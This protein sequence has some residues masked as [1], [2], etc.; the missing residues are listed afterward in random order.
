MKKA[1]IAVDIQN[2]FVEGGALGC[3]GGK[4]VARGTK[5]LI[6]ESEDR[7]AYYLYISTQDWHKGEG[8][9]N[10][11]HIEDRPNFVD[12][13]PAHC[14]GGT[15]GAEFCRPLEAIDFDYRILKGYETPSYS[16][17]SDN[18]YEAND[19]SLSL[20]EILES[21]GITEVDIVGIAFDYCVA[22]TAKDAAE[23]GFKVRVLKPLTATINKA[24]EERIVEDLASRGIEVLER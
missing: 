11:G 8:C 18:A 9:T 13:W 22:Q 4:S 14:I 24:S 19:E 21:R 1:L 16:G 3:K 6:Q 10:G 7:D 2:D 5:D 15:E 23:K 20:V 17:F 12:S